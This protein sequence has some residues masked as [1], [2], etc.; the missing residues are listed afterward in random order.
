M[1]TEEELNQK[2]LNKYA[3]WKQPADVVP[4]TPDTPHNIEN[5]TF[6][7]ALEK[8]FWESGGI[9][10]LN[11]VAKE[12]PLEFLKICAKLIPVEMKGLDS[13]ANLTIVVNTLEDATD[14]EKTIEHL[15]E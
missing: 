5:L 14:S 3:S 11:R 4:I 12:N 8:S 6:S 15:E 10:L 2:L 7:E 1:S 9:T 13:N